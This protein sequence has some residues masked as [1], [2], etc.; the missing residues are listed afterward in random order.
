MSVQEN[1]EKTISS[2]SDKTRPALVSRRAL[3]KRGAISMP[4]I[5]TLQ[6]GAALARSSNMISASATGTTD[7]IGRTLCLDT[8]SVYPVA[9]SAD[10]YDL[11][12]PA[13]ATVNIISDRDYYLFPESGSKKKKKNKKKKSKKKKMSKATRVTAGNMCEDGGTYWWKPTS[14][15]WQPVDLP[16]NGIVLSTGAVTSIADIITDNL[17]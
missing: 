12:T 5:L 15:D 7:N 13:E 14:G 2:T 17:I 10:L 3:L 16:Y 9:N 1:K 6:S 11:G 4:A 8:N